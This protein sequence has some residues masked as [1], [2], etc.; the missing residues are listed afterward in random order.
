MPP[1]YLILLVR[2]SSSRSSVMVILRFRLRN[3]VSRMRVDKRV[4]VEVGRLEDLRV[5]PERDR[6][7]RGLG[8][9]RRLELALRL[10]VLVRLGPDLAVALDLDLESLGEG[11]DDGDADAVEA[12]GDL[13]SLSAELAAS[14]QDGE[15]DLHAGLAVL[16]DVV[17]RDA[18]P[19]VDHRDGVSWWMVT[20]IAVQCPASASSTELSTTS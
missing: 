4:E 2:G 19:V 8:A 14:V 17:D 9:S 1:A 5:R 3:A 6:G 11:V 15:D 16:G 13:V 18:S 20:S 12:A 10:P 7:P